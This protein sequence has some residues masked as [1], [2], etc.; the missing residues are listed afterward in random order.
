MRDFIA[1]LLSASSSVSFN[2]NAARRG[3]SRAEFIAKLGIVVEE[4]DETV[5]WLE[6]LRDTGIAHDPVL[7]IEAKELCAI[8]TAALK[9]ARLNAKR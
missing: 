7:L 4:A 8:F 2:Y 1:Q 3:R 6:F 9:T 5:G